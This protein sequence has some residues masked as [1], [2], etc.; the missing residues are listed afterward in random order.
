LPDVL[1]IRGGEELM[2]RVEKLDRRHLKGALKTM[3]DHV[4]TKAKPYPRQPPTDYVRTFHLMDSWKVKP[5]VRDFAVQVGNRAEYA[6]YVH[7][8]KRQ[9]G[10]HRSSGWKRLRET[11]Q[12]EMDKLVNI[13]KKQ[14]D[15]I[16]EGR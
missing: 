6:P 9:A 13:L 11:A 4:V 12:N 2:R 3:G 8:D 15:R 14:V 1:E 10:I 7:G 5:K 16:L